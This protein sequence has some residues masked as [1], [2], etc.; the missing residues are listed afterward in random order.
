MGTTHTSSCNDAACHTS[1]HARLPAGRGG[2]RDFSYADYDRPC[3]VTLGWNCGENRAWVLIIVNPAYVDSSWPQ[4]PPTRPTSQA[5]S[6]TA[7]NKS[8]PKVPATAVLMEEWKKEYPHII[9]T[10]HKGR[11][12]HQKAQCS[13]CLQHNPQQ[14]V[15]W[16]NKNSEGSV[17]TTK[18]EI[19]T[20]MKSEGH[21]RALEIKDAEEGAPGGI[22]HAMS[23]MAAKAAMIVR[24]QLPILLLATLYIIT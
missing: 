3:F 17:I 10:G 12:G 19:T 15:L 24:G 4:Q 16:A 2:H 7:S 11:H 1:P 22:K 8:K 9:Y 14:K 18:N 6:N 23:V 21:V 5:Q 13:C 20:H